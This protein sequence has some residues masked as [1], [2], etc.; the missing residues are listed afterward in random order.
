M[1]RK[2]SRRARCLSAGRPTGA[3]SAG[4]PGGAVG[5]SRRISP[6]DLSESIRGPR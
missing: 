3:A 6:W 2:A 5:A 4:A 1:A